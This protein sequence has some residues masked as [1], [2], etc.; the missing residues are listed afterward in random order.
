MNNFE[1]TKYLEVAYEATAPDRSRKDCGSSKNKNIR[2]LDQADYPLAAAP[3]FE[4][5]LSRQRL[6]K[7]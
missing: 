4:T 6:R 1:M 5:L 7:V 2:Y 3:D